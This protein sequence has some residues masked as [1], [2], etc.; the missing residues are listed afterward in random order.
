MLPKSASPR[1]ARA[2]AANLQ[3]AEIA[4]QRQPR[5]HAEELGPWTRGERRQ[6][7]RHPRVLPHE[8]VAER[9]ARPPVPDDGGLALV[10]D[11]DRGEVAC[12]QPPG[13]QRAGDD[14]LRVSPDFYR[15]MLDPSRLRIDLR[16]LDL[17]LGDDPGGLVEHDEA[18]AAGALIDRSKKSRH[19]VSS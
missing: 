1:S 19:E 13:A 7:F 6:V 4:R 3:A 8:R 12:L 5:A 14:R 17:R 16:V 9:H 10:G 15:V 11:A 2:L 18:S